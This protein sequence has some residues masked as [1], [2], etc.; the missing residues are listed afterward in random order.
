M[1]HFVLAAVPSRTKNGGRCTH[2]PGA[3]R[4]IALV[5]RAHVAGVFIVVYDFF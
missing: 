5:K 1:I 3:D 4:V 2:H